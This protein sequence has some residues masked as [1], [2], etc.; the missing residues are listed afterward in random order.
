MLCLLQEFCPLVSTKLVE[1][2]A[3]LI[4]HH[5]SLALRA[6]QQHQGSNVNAFPRLQ[7]QHFFQCHSGSIAET[8]FELV[9]T[10][11]QNS[12]PLLENIFEVDAIGRLCG[13]WCASSV[14]P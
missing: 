7:Q 13:I 12:E 2:G 14:I 5:V 4:L 8:P 1:S 6:P 9:R 10:T 11:L 3:Q